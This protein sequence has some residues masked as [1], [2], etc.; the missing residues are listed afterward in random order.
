ML[1]PAAAPGTGPARASDGSAG[2]ASQSCHGASRAALCHRL[3]GPVDDAPQTRQPAVAAS[4]ND[5]AMNDIRIL[6]ALVSTLEIGPRA[7][8]GNLALLPLL[9]SRQRGSTDPQ[10]YFLDQQ[11][12][13]AGLISIE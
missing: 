9:A 10:S 3:I 1:G 7:R 4:P 2:R 5:R 12:H 13:D 8:A 11:G 6:I